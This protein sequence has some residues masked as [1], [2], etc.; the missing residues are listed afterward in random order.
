MSSLLLHPES[1]PVATAAKDAATSAGSAP[2]RI[3]FV[4]DDEEDYLLTLALLRKI[5]EF[6][7]T[8]EWVSRAEAVL[9]RLREGIW[10]ICLLDYRLRRT[11][12]LEI[13]RQARAEGIPVPIVLL[14][15]QG[16]RSID[17]EALAAGASDFL[18][19]GESDAVTLE[20]SIHYTI[21]Q[22]KIEE[23]LRAQ[24]D[25]TNAVLDTAAAL[26]LVL[27]REGRI[28]RFNP[29]CEKA[30]GYSFD[31][32][33]GTRIWEILF[34]EEEQDTAADRLAEALDVSRYPNQYEAPM[35]TRFGETRTIIWRNSCLLDNRGQEIEFLVSVGIDVT[36]QRLIEE[37]LAEARRREVEVGASIQSALLV[38]QPPL[39]FPGLSFQSFTQPSQV[40]NGDFTDYYSLGNGILD[41][42]VGDVMGKGVAAALIGAAAKSHLQRVMRRLTLALRPYN[43]LPEPHEIITAVHK[44]LTPELQE[45]H[46]FVTLTY[47]RFDLHRGCMTIVDCGAPP[48]LHWQAAQAACIRRTGDNL[49]IGVHRV[50]V[51][52]QFTVPIAPG[53]VLL[54]YSDGLTDAYQQ[55]TDDYFGVNR[56]EQVFSENT[57]E[58]VPVLIERVIQTV[59]GFGGNR[60][61]ADFDDLTCLA[62]RV[63]NAGMPAPRKQMALDLKS[64]PAETDRVRNW[65]SDVLDIHFP[66]ASEEDRFMTEVGLVEAFGNIVRH[67]YRGQMDRP[68]FL[69]AEVYE[70]QLV[71][72]LLDWGEVCFRPEDVREPSFDGSPNGYGLF[73]I[74]QSYESV[75]FGQDEIGRNTLYLSRTFNA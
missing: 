59:K 1:L 47:A 60:T 19:K 48:P 7:F 40:I 73:I 30:S 22:K 3:L 39:D 68:V 72:K 15:G 74:R 10:D 14:T 63:E 24:N 12:G 75:H 21:A 4:D 23:Q 34:P 8:V 62:I 6:S 36:E 66:G 13:L 50:E 46:S 25:F 55:E 70:Q 35:V 53:D 43:R 26:V 9:P 5:E 38:R 65:L 28:V 64:D 69:E 11:T 33:R 61:T 18:V 20:R 67:A 58:P 54:F 71:L 57:S 32:L 31:E 27:D 49:P 52:R 42:V 45:L 44:L 51:Y 16:D 2:L 56:L 29:A 37:E 17:Q 41:V